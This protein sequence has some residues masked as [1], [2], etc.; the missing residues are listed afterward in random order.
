MN[1]G[2]W[3]MQFTERLYPVLLPATGVP[4]IKVQRLAHMEKFY[5]WDPE[6]RGASKIWKRVCLSS[7]LFFCFA[8][9]C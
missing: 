1:L 7:L 4:P 9:I 5:F 2:K 6:T 3:E 8:L